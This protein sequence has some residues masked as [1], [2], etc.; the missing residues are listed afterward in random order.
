MANTYTWKIESIKQSTQ[1]ING[2]N[3]VVLNCGWSC[4][5]ESSQTYT[6][7]QGKLVPYAT[8]VY[9][10]CSFPE[11]IVGDPN[12]IPYENLTETI[13]L[14]WI[15]QSGAYKISTQTAIDNQLNDLI[16]PP[17]IESKL[18]WA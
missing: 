3:K 9:G 8:S 7:S 15:W 1:T 6:D 4:K 12:F 5:G 17:V 10:S 2:F 13:V 16:N 14:N 18:P 11:P